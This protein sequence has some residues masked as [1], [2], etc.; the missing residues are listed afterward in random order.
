MVSQGHPPERK[1]RTRPDAHAN[2]H[3]HACTHTHASRRPDRAHKNPG[4][5]AAAAAAATAAA[6][7]AATTAAAMWERGA[8][9]VDRR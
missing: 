1:H 8:K 2:T 7:A 4:P 3:T 9:Y 6:V 5:A